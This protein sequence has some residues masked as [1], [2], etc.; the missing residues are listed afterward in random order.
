M[1]IKK[2]NIIIII[3]VILRNFTNLVSLKKYVLDVKIKKFPKK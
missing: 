2:D 3:M 1:V